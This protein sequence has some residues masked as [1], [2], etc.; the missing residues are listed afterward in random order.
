ML[1]RIAPGSTAYVLGND[2]FTAVALPIG[3]SRLIVSGALDASAF[4][5]IRLKTTNI[6]L[7]NGVALAASSGFTF[8]YVVSGA[9][10]DTAG[11]GT[12]VTV[13]F[14]ASGNILHL[15]VAYAY[16]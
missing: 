4:P 10:C 11:V 12:G 13:R 5:I 2:A 15:I 1:A 6:N 16:A 14:S 8:E 3:C 9:D 7:N